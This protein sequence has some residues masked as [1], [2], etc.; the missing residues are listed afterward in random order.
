MKHFKTY[1]QFI[2]ESKKDFKPHMMYDPETGKGYKAETYED[3]LKMDKMG[4]VHEKPEVTEGGKGNAM[5]YFKAK[6]KKKS[7]RDARKY[8]KKKREDEES[9]EDLEFKASAKMQKESLNEGGMDELDSLAQDSKD[10]ESFKRE[11]LKE[12]PKFKGKKGTDEWLEGIYKMANESVVTE[13]KH[14]YIDIKDLHFEMDPDVQDEMKL[15]IGTRT[16][17]VTRREK[18]DNADYELKRFR[19]K[20]KYWDGNKRDEDF[21]VDVFA[22]PDH[23]NTVHSTLGGGPHAKIIKP[24][25]WN[26]KLYDKWI[27]DMASGEGWKHSFD[28]AQNATHEP[29]LTAWVKKTYRER[30]PLQRIQWDIEALGESVKQSLLHE[31]LK[32]KYGSV[33]TD[34]QEDLTK[35]QQ[36]HWAMHADLYD[37]LSKSNDANREADKLSQSIKDSKRKEALQYFLDIV[38]NGGVK[39]NQKIK[40]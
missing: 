30:D 9:P 23:Y 17:G 5:R 7:Q 20:I 27:E 6:E 28:M 25:K 31:S 18:I 26:Q 29:G 14:R 13:N 4:Y 39:K 40:A 16:G 37:R 33:Y 35:P 22:G 11:A 3:H 15:E 1:Q 34:L 38:L 2:N 8:D 24:K 21:A 10:L 12:Y 36:F 32:S 19:K